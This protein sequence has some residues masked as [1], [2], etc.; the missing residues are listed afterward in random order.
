M[1]NRN[2]DR[3]CPNFI[4]S[5]SITVVTVDGVDTLVIDIP[6]PASAYYNCRKICLALTEAIPDAATLEMPVAISIGGDTTT[7]YPIVDCTGLQ[8]VAKQIVTR[9]KYKL[10]VFTN[11][12]SGVFKVYNL[13]NCISRTVLPTLEV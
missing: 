11:A 13:P 4:F 9:Y 8:I 6:A 3:F 10:K 5:D 7:V 1:C 12:T 2:C